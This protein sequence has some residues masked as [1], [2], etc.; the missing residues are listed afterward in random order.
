LCRG[1]SPHPLLAALTPF[2]YF[3]DDRLLPRGA[4]SFWNIKDTRTVEGSAN[5]PGPACRTL[6]WMA[7]APVG[8]SHNVPGLLSIVPQGGPQNET[9]CYSFGSRH[10]GSSRNTRQSRKPC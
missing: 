3:L 2:S 8:V 9:R 10:A 1:R 7:G 6:G 5:N 4:S